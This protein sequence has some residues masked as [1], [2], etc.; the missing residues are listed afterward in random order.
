VRRLRGRR[1]H[2]GAADPGEVE[3]AVAVG[4][5][6]AAAGEAV[7]EPLLFHATFEAA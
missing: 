7:G 3:V 5:G 1:A 4:V 2:G 6:G